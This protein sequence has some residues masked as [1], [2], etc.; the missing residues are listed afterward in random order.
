MPNIKK[1][2]SQVTRVAG[3]FAPAVGD[4]VSFAIAKQGMNV[5]LQE[6]STSKQELTIS[7][8]HPVH[9]KYLIAKET[10]LLTSSIA[11]ITVL[12]YLAK[13]VISG[14]PGI[15]HPQESLFKIFGGDKIF[16]GGMKDDV[17]AF[18]AINIILCVAA[19]AVLAHYEN[20]EDKAGFALGGAATYLF[21]KPLD[22]FITLPETDLQVTS[23]AVFSPAPEETDLNKGDSS[24]IITPSL[25]LLPNE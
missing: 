14:I 23:P 24:Y 5:I 9:Q 19:R 17:I 8:G 1:D 4:L 20:L 13:N 16:D 10:A 18:L 21:Q 7:K 3:F 11:V 12:G 15:S 6:K 2:L 25:L 22:V